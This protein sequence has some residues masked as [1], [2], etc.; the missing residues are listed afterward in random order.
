MP[1]RTSTL[2]AVGSWV[3]TEATATTCGSVRSLSATFTETGAP[4]TP[5]SSDEPGG[6]TMMSAPMPACRVLLSFSIPSMMPT[7]RSMSVTSTAT[8][9]TLMMVRNGRCTRLARIIRFMGRVRLYRMRM[10]DRM[11]LLEEES[12]GP[13][14]GPS[15]LPS[16]KH[17]ML[18]S[19]ENHFTTETRRTRSFGFYGVFLRDLR[20]SVVDFHS[21]GWTA[22]Q[23][24][25]QYHSTT[26]E[27][28]WRRA[29]SEERKAFTALDRKSTRLNSSH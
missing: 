1:S 23:C 7:I 24:D 28:L 25:T 26:V 20:A 14:Y 4:L 13:E 17:A 29:R 10:G 15:T 12:G 16:Q 18:R 22:G 19:A 11:G 27:S 2:P 8:A 5:I 21:Y 9:T 6:C 3:T